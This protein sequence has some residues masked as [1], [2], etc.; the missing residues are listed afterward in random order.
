[1]GKRAEHVYTDKVG[2]RHIES[3]IDELP[4]NSHVRLSL[5]DGSHCDGVVS[6]RPTVQVFRDTGEREGINAL[7]QLQRP[8]MPD[9]S[10][11]VWV[12]QIVRVVHLDSTM[13]SES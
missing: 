12:D 6:V 11:Q 13:G 5:K 3:L 8:D 9:W 10:R 7:V 1:M 4:G 2:I